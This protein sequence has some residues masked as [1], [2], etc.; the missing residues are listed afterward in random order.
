MQLGPNAKTGA[1]VVAVGGVAS[2]SNQ[3]FTV[4]P[5]NIYFIDNVS[6]SDSNAGTFAAPYKSLTPAVANLKPG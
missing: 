5:G 6:G 2:N 4:S 1:I 3:G